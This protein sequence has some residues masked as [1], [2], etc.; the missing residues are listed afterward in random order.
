LAIS[1]NESKAVLGMK[2]YQPFINKLIP[3]SNFNQ[4]IKSSSR[5]EKLSSVYQRTSTLGPFQQTNQSISPNK[6]PSSVI[7]QVLHLGHFDQLIKSISLNKKPSSV[8][9]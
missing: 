1:I 5:N 3:L 7:N 2:S 6:K 9:K 4:Q 8:I